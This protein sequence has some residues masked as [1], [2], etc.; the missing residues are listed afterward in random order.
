MTN[1]EYIGELKDIPD[2]MRD[3]EYIFRGYR[4]G[5]NS[6][7]KILKSLFMIHNES[8][9]VWSH[10]IGAFFFILLIFYTLFYLAPPGLYTKVAGDLRSKWIEDKKDSTLNRQ[11]ILS[12]LLLNINHLEVCYK[13]Y[14]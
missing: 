12:E 8:V 4:I 2:F 11:A 9:N 3:N 10:L 14:S 13:I 6:K 7:R 1:I 5:F